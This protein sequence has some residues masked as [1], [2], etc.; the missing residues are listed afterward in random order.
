MLKHCRINGFYHS[1]GCTKKE[2]LIHTANDNCFHLYD[3]NNV[4]IHTFISFQ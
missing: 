2:V 4:L 3:I 1:L